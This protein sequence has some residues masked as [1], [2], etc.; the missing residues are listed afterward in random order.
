MRNKTISVWIITIAA[1]L[2]ALLFLIRN[3]TFFNE[4]IYINAEHSNIELANVESCLQCHKNTKGYS[5]YHNPELIGCASCHLGN[6]KS[7]KK[8]DAHRGM[9]LVPGNLSDAKETCGKCHASELHKI[10]NS[11]MTTNSG[12]VA[13]DKFIFGEA[14]SLN[15]HYHIKDIQ[16]SASDK[17]LRDL[18]ANCHLGAEKTSYGEINQLSRGGGCNACHLNYSGEAKNDLKNYLASNKTELPQFHPSTDIFVNDTHCFGCHSRSSRISTNYMGL[19]E[20]LLDKD[21]V[22]N[23]EILAV[24]RQT[25]HRDLQ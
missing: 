5:N 14:D 17:H 18:C 22:V 25:V 15:D 16:Y 2:F 13:V 8:D 11:L 12:I 1:L 20:T 9:I 7:L 21:E 4:P 19:Q 23:M 3:N 6:T 10:E 24:K